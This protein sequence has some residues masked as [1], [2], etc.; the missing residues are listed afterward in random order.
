MPDPAP[1]SSGWR[2]FFNHPAGLYPLFFTEMWERFSFYTML[3]LLALYTKNYLG[4]SAEKSSDVTTWYLSLVYFTPFI[5]GLIADRVTGYVRAIALGGVLMMIG[6]L[7]LA[8]DRRD[9]VGHVCLYSALVLMVLG[10][11]LFKPNIST[12]VGSLYAPNDPRRDQGFTI[13]YM[14][15]NLGAFFAPLAAS[16]LRQNSVEWVRRLTPWS[17][18]DDAGWHIAF[19]SAG[20]GMLASLIIFGSFRR[21]F[22]ALE[23]K[24]SGHDGQAAPGRRRDA[25]AEETPADGDEGTIR[26]GQWFNMIGVT[27]ALAWLFAGPHIAWP[28]SIRAVALWPTRME[29]FIFVWL[30]IEAATVMI[31]LSGG[32]MAS[33]NAA[34]LKAVFVIVALFWMAF[35][36]NS[37]TLTFFAE[38]HTVTP[39]DPGKLLAIDRVLRLPLRPVI[40][41][42]RM[43]TQAPE[44][45]AAI[46][47]F[48][49]LLF[50]PLMVLL[51]SWLGRRGRE[52]SSVSK[53]ILAMFVTG[54]AY[55]VMVGAGLSGG[56]SGRV[57]PLWLIGCYA[58]L[59]VAELW[60]SPIGLSLTSRLAPPRYRGLWMGFWFVATAVGNKLVHVIGQYWDTVPPSQLFLVLV[61]TSVGAA[62]ALNYILVLL[63]RFGPPST[64]A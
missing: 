32:D 54:L 12:I 20:V 5:G 4:F 39:W 34:K 26:F 37:V 43:T 9:A 55:L 40:W 7:V 44:A 17:V 30:A 63:R 31:F 15:I 18:P 28:E 14:G 2:S 45:F 61:F 27:L 50:S 35:H 46:N 57:S 58:L 3:A 52:P 53:M 11:G 62:V 41:L 60:L 19:G 22:T 8:M 33:A 47:P 10:N 64:D 13:F 59:T 25:A 42:L 23:S 56:D 49:I 36:Q 1:R 38:Q 51:W 29:N 16:E 6:P 21:R 48:F 24:R